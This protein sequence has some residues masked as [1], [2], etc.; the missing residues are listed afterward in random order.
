M[1]KSDEGDW[2]KLIRLMNYLKKTIDGV[3]IMG[4]DIIEEFFIWVDTTYA[5]HDYM[6]S[7]TGGTIS[8]GHGN[9]N[10]LLIKKK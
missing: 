9:V 5:V 6:K 4:A 7:Q 10:F 1:S 2:S 3:R 8:F